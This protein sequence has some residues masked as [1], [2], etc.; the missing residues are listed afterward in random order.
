VHMQIIV[1]NPTSN[2]I[3]DL[4]RVCCGLDTNLILGS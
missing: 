4:S 1:P 3:A 2:R